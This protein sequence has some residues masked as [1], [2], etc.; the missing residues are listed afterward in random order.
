MKLTTKHILSLL[1]LLPV[2]IY[3]FGS[4]R[5]VATGIALVSAAQIPFSPEFDT[6]VAEGRA[7]E[8]RGGDR[9]FWVGYGQENNF[10]IQR[11]LLQFTISE[12]DIPFGS[13]ITSATLKLHLAGWLSE[14]QSMIVKVARLRNDWAE[15]ITWNQHSRLLPADPDH[16]VEISVGTD[17]VEY[18]W[19][20]KEMLQKWTNDTERGGAI[21]LLITSDESAKQHDRGFWSKNCTETQCVGKQPVLEIQFELPP[22]ATPTNTTFPS[23]TPTATPTHTP[24]PVSISLSAGTATPTSTPM[25]Q[26]SQTPTLVPT[27]LTKIPG[28]D[29]RPNDQIVY[30][31]HYEVTSPINSAR[32][33]NP[34][35]LYVTPV[36]L[37]EGE[38]DKNENKVTWNLGSL[39][40]GVSGERSYVVRYSPAPQ[41]SVVISVSPDTPTIGSTVT[42]GLES[43]N[44]PENIVM[45]VWNFGEGEPKEA[46]FLPVSHVYERARTY[47]VTLRAETATCYFTATTTVEILNETDAGTT[48]V[49]TLPAQPTE[50]TQTL[51]PCN[52]LPAVTNN[53]AVMT[54]ETIQGRGVIT[55]NSSILNPEILYMPIVAR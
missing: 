34:L 1:I 41:R 51:P 9:T 28:V 46:R 26:S 27:L 23:S 29:V 37:N 50:I 55:S 43:Q 14:E 21:S 36:D 2:C 22:T 48:M 7:G 16:A 45:Y 39:S 42:F 38:L 10:K 32:I 17:L 18:R 19:N 24:L 8:S 11:S 44:V 47:T 3:S 15:N 53:G 25:P 33:V 13:T 20:L 54:W 5:F 35:P 30:T 31:I 12:N 52:T 49:E 4:S 40:A 6:F